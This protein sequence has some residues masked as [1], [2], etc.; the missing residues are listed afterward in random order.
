MHLPTLIIVTLLINLIIGFY[1]FVLYKRRPKDS[2]FRYWSYSCFCFVAGGVAGAMREFELHPF[3]SFFIADVLLVCAPLLVFVGLIQFSRYRFTKAKRKGAY[4]LFALVVVALLLTFWHPQLSSV[5]SAVSVAYIFWQCSLLLH[6]SVFNEPIYTKVLYAIFVIHSLVMLTQAVL[7][8]LN[9]LQASP[10]MPAANT[11]YTL[12]S[13]ILLS[14]LTALLLP[15]LSFLKLERKLTLRTQRDGLTN[16]ANRSYFI[17][18]VDKRWAERKDI[19]AILMMIDIDHFKAINDKFGHAMGDLALAKVAKALSNGLRCH[20]LVARIGGEEFAVLLDVAEI[21]LAKKI[22]ERLRH[23]VEQEMATLA[24][25][26]LDLTISIGIIQALPD[27]QSA[28]AAFKA[29]DD[30]LYTSKNN[31]RNTLSVGNFS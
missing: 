14:T 2:C 1:L 5:I 18:Q 8:S 25:K 15:W 9:W 23:Q 11:I 31:G 24:D 22:G 4:R 26:Q 30:A 13:H 21:E 28:L 29:A 7:L 19:P 20:D 6:R 12:L 3:V 16:L 10:P 17:H 27:E